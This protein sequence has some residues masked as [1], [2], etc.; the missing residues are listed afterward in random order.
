MKT[1][2]T[3]SFF[4]AGGLAAVLTALGATTGDRL[5]IP[6][7]TPVPGILEIGSVKQTF[8]DSRV[9]HEVSMISS[10]VR[11]PHKYEK[12]PV[13]VPDRPWEKEE[14]K[15]VPGFTTFSGL[16]ITGQTVIYDEEEKIFKMW[17]MPH[18]V[19]K[20]G[21]P[22]WGRRPWCYATSRD[23]Y[24]WEKPN[25]GLY[26]Y[27]GSKENNI[28]LDWGDPCM[29]N[30]MK[31]PRE[32]DPQRRYKALGEVEGAVANHTGGVAIAFSPDGL[33]WTPYPGNPVVKHGRNIGDAPTI[34]GWSPAKQKY[35]AF[36]RPGHP[37]APEINGRGDHRHIRS[38]GY[39]ESDD[40][41]HWT[42]TELMM[43]P[44]DEDR[45]DTQY[46]QFTAGIDG[47]FYIG[48]NALHQTH[49]QTW[50]IFLMTSRD[51]FHWNWA[52]RH[53][54]YIPRGE[55]GTYDAGYMT[56]SGPI[57]HDGKVWIF[58][59]AFSGAHSYLPTRLGDHSR[60][61]VA[62]CTVPQ[63]RW[64]GLLAGPS[65]GIIVTRPLVFTGSKL[66]VDLDASVADQAPRIPPHF[67]ECDL[68]AALCDQ[69]GGV[70]PGFTIERSTVITRSGEQEISWSGADLATLAGKPVRIRFELRNAALYSFQ[71]H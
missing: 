54:P 4:A 63:N 25:L 55:A 1:F 26:E 9:I 30:V 57:Y 56:P 32:K 7:R 17:Y 19:W 33:R 22:Q 70:L 64:V 15:I 67:D 21:D 43:A 16:V 37:L 53:V 6:A 8:L 69:S 44:D 24:N 45:V 38:Y 51:A 50:D 58:Y 18:V 13:L 46:M 49:E 62:L 27:E 34:L 71:F 10:F 35:I 31:D 2:F 60:F 47:E 61:S 42:P 12:N 5:V 48:F 29:F 66:I 28:L 65:Q 59:G 11:R 41:I 52:D 20:G 23:G 39:S 14:A 68:R 3:W 40:F 36:Y